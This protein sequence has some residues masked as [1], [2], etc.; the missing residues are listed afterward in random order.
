MA[1]TKT[2]IDQKELEAEIKKLEASG[3]Y[4]SHNELF[5][6]LAKTD[7]A[8]AGKFSANVLRSRTTDY[9]IELTTPVGKRGRKPS[10]EKDEKAEKPA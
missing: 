5:N 10:T 4:T 3:Q 9:K 2:V 1:R 6:A 7:W 8:T